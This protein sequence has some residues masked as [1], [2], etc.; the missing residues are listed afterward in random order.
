MLH[1]AGIDNARY[2][3]RRLLGH[4]LQCDSTALLLRRDDMPDL[5]AADA[6]L[7][8]RCAREPMA[9]ITG[10]AGFWSLD[11]ATSPVTLIPRPE[12]ETLIEAV[13]ARWPD[14][15]MGLRVLDLGTG[16]GCLLLAVLSEYRNAYG[17]GVDLVPEAARL[18]AENAYR[19][20]LGRRASFLVGEWAATLRGAF[21]LVLSNPPYIP[22][23]EISGLMPE[24][25]QHEPAI[26]LDGGGDGMDA[27]RVVIGSLPRLLAVHGCAAL[28]V[29][30][31]QSDA[32]AELGRA[33][34]FEAVP[35]VDL[36]GVERVLV[37]QRN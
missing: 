2:E 21:D 15:T 31:G 4:A 12:S 7:A 5:E 16:T 29:G 26:A 33:M 14:R 19:N 11:L 13:M 30:A 9:F 10:S 17:V 8:R 6:L 25:A 34:K 20:G 28:E 22:S 23:A 32:V 24:V 37:L 36:G 3:A 1:E 35:H 27:Y 18:A